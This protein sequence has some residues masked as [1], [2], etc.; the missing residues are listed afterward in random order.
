MHPCPRMEELG[1]VNSRLKFPRDSHW[2][3]DN[4]CSHCGSMN[5]EEL[6]EKIEDGS[7]SIVP[8]DKNYKIYVEGTGRNRKFYFQHFSDKECQKFVDLLNDG[9]IQ[10]RGSTGFYVMPFF[11]KVGPRMTAAEAPTL[12]GDF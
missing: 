10:F 3:E 5:P 2:R 8:T 7:A 12:G 9:K 11:L 4:T 6:F 1:G